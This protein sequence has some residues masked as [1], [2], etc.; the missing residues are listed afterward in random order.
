MKTRQVYNGPRV[1]EFIEA[2]L[3]VYQYFLDEKFFN[4]KCLGEISFGPKIYILEKT[5]DKK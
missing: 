2:I 1:V 5:F 4:K 3:S